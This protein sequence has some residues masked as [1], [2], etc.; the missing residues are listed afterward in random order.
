MGLLSTSDS[1][2]SRR[3]LLVLGVL[4]LAT[5]LV[6]TWLDS[7]P[8]P[9]AVEDAVTDVERIEA[10]RPPDTP[11]PA[12]SEFEARVA[13]LDLNAAPEPLPERVTD[14]D[15]L[16]YVNTTRAFLLWFFDA[17]GYTADQVDD[18][19]TS[20]VPPVVLLNIPAGWAEDTS[21]S[22]KKS[23]FY[24]TLLPL[25]LLENEAVLAERASLE[26]YRKQR[27]NRAPISREAHAAARALAVR[28]GVI[29]ADAAET[30]DEADLAE[31]LRR[32]DA[33]PP[34]LA[35]G[36]AAYESGYATSR[37]A[38]EGNA[39]FGQWDWGADAL[40]PGKPRPEKGDYGIRAFPYPLDSVRAYLRNLNTHRAY[41]AFRA[42]RERQRD[43]REGRVT[44]DGHALAATLTAYSERGAEYTQTLQ[45]MIRH[46][47][48]E[49][50]DGLRLL[51][52]DPVYFH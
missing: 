24:R 13:G 52:G 34:S 30:L 45:G 18:S 4:M 22:L 37:F 50:A 26:A 46:N 17:V 5:G 33:V 14:E 15:Y 38:H 29:A 43:G 39:L 3:I 32:V 2:A 16:L 19:A 6:W 11:S 21:V 7:A 51:E 1:A 27:L 47:R 25:V 40:K 31:L 12:P 48:L 44:F 10:T 49:R 9:I 28:Y 20:V 23:L 42:L 8:G 35:L 41:A 36:Q